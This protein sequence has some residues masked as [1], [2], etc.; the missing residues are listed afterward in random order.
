MIFFLQ[1]WANVNQTEV[2]ALRTNSWTSLSKP[3]LEHVGTFGILIW[4]DRCSN[5]R[6]R[7]SQPKKSDCHSLTLV[8]QCR[9]LCPGGSCYQSSISK[10]LHSQSNLQQSIRSLGLFPLPKTLDEYQKGVGRHLSSHRHHIGDSW[11][12]IQMDTDLD[13]VMLP[14]WLQF[15][16]LCWSFR[17]A[18]CVYNC[19]FSHVY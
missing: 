13:R 7:Q 8:T 12:R 19:L 2:R 5:K 17:T 3:I 15:G 1:I 10:N 9:F 11:T 6:R 14:T 16:P 4:H 18:F